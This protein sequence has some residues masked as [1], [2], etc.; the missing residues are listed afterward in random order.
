MAPLP[1]IDTDPRLRR[2][3]GWVLGGTLLA[4]MLLWGYVGI[5]HHGIGPHRFDDFHYA[6]NA[7]AGRYDRGVRFRYVHIWALR[8]FYAAFDSRLLAAAA[9]GTAMQVGLIGAA[10]VLG[11]L[12]AGW[13]AG[14]MAALLLPFFPS[15]WMFVSTPLVDPPCTLYAGLGLACMMPWQGKGH[16]GRWAL[17]SGLLCFASIKCKETGVAVLPAVGLLMLQQPGKRL[18]LLR[19][20]LYGALLGQA[21]LCAADG[22]I[23]GDPWKSL[24]FD[25]FSQYAAKIGGAPVVPHK[26]RSLMRD[27]WVELWLEKGTRDYLLLGLFGMALGLRRNPRLT[28]LCFWLVCTQLF[29]A[30]VSWRYAGI[31]AHV[32]YLVPMAL[33]LVVAAGG[34]LSWFWEGPSEDPMPAVVS[35]PGEGVGVAAANWLQRHGPVALCALGVAWVAYHGIAA[36]VADALHRKRLDY[37]QARSLFFLLPLTP[38]LCL[39]VARLAPTA[40]LRRPAIVTILVALPLLAWPPTRHYIDKSRRANLPWQ[41]LGSYM[42]R[43]HTSDVV[44]FRIGH[45]QIQAG[46]LRWRLAALSPVAPEALSLTDAK[47]LDGIS[48]DALLITDATDTTT[49]QELREAGWKPLL[50]LPRGK[51][52]MRVY[53]HD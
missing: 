36:G 18:A 9:Y 49:G 11:K 33:P 21:L 44:R 37:A 35:A 4:W 20:W 48:D 40:W 7:L 26:R 42:G 16:P 43:R 38:L 29:S 15:L 17:L 41:R 32:R 30:W 1:R 12:A 22:A 23:L 8:A 50:V 31:D 24:R 5:V 34:L 46:L 39:F 3:A 47:A 25:V 51:I 19:T 2:A 10:F 53:R 45:R 6:Y 52:R 13:R 28:V 14:L 27:G